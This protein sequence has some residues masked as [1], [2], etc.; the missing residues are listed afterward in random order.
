MHCAAGS[1]CASGMREIGVVS[2]LLAA[3]AMIARHAGVES[4][5]SAER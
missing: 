2:Y 4:A 5:R 3:A 1:A